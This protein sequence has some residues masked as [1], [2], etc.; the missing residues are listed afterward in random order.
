VST[1]TPSND[2][3]PKPEPSDLVWGAT[4]IAEVLNVNR[5]QAFFSFGKQKNPGAENRRAM[6]RQQGAAART[7]RRMSQPIHKKLPGAGMPDGRTADFA[8]TAPRTIHAT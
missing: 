8:G 5:R 2:T 4:G 6:V 3:R 1:E 7:L